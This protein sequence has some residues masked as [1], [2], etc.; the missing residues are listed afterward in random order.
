MAVA[1]NMGRRPFV[2]GSDARSSDEAA[3][4]RL[5]R[6]K[7][8]EAKPDNAIATLGL[9]TTFGCPA[10]TAYKSFLA[11]L[12]DHPPRL[13][14]ID[15]DSTA[16]EDRAEHL[17]AV[18]GEIVAYLTIVLDD[19]AQNVPGG[20][21]LRDAEAILAD[22]AGDLIGAIQHAADQMADDMVGRVE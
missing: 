21:E 2:G 7:H 3:I 20:L 12:A 18:F 13:I 10:T 16:L 14:P 17:S 1:L 4:P 11:S 19:T 9:P 8:G 5:R 6:D 15:A 22:L